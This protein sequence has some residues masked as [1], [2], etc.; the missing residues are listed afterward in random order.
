MKQ[1]EQVFRNE[2]NHAIDFDKV[3]SQFASKASFSLSRQGIE[4]A[5]PS[6]DLFSI[7]EQL[8]IGCGGKSV[9]EKITR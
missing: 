5:L 1:N 4:Q 8:E 9:W 6:Q 3:L 2:L 7:K